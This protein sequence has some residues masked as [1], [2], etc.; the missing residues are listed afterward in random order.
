[1]VV[2]A[3]FGCLVYKFALYLSMKASKMDL[4][5]QKILNTSPIFYM[6]DFLGNIFLS[7]F[8]LTIILYRKKI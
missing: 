4:S 2:H 6:P 1:V 3:T 8:D 5:K 7:L